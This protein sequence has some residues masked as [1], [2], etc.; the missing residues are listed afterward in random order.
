VLGN[1]YSEPP[2][3]IFNGERYK[4]LR[5]LVLSGE[6]RYCPAAGR[7]CLL[8]GM[9]VDGRESESGHTVRSLQIEPTTACNLRCLT[10]LVRDIHPARGQATDGDTRF[11]VW[12]RARRAKQ[13]L[14]PLVR[15]LP[16][17]NG[18]HPSGPVTGLLTRGRMPKGR[19]GTLPLGVIETVIDDLAGSLERIDL[20][21]YGE[22]FLYPH[23]VDALRH[24]RRRCPG[25]TVNLSTNGIPIAEETE[26]AIVSELLADWILFSID[27]VNAD[28]YGFY[29]AGGSF[30]TA[31]DHLLRFHRKAQSSGV[32]VV[33]Q[34][35]VFRW[36]DTDRELARALE[37]AGEYG[38]T[39]WF[40]FVRA[41]G[42]STR[43]EKELTHLLP[44]LKPGTALPSGG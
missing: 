2:T 38:L 30:Q 18:P 5:R 26:E 19:G 6:G 42:R 20:F 7:N 10:C 33:W 12:N 23:L 35:L 31:W 15:R 40:E 9:T 4:K 22:P 8:K 16:G 17:L 34:Y 44:H 24:I 36:N 1:V 39:L 14:A 43:K 27:G 37:L 28:T 13:G 25:V 3:A 41:W 21:N 11:R 32:N 29:R